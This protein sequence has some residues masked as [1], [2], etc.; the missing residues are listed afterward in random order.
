MGAITEPKS[1]SYI[2]LDEIDNNYFLTTVRPY[3]I[4]DEKI[5]YS[6]KGIRDGVIFTDKR[7][8]GIDVQGVTGKKK[9]ITSFPYSRIQAFSFEHAGTLDL[10]IELILWINSFEFVSFKFEADIDISPVYQLIGE[11]VLL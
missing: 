9:R 3:L 4:G 6:F 1:I 2:R 11:R 7:I 10:D 5:I 8:I